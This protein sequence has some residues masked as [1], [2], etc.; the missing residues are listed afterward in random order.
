M[1]GLVELQEGILVKSEG[2]CWRHVTKRSGT[3][4]V[5][6]GARWDKSIIEAAIGR[7]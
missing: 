4:P 5:Q 1:N 2:R 6:I 7:I 3:L